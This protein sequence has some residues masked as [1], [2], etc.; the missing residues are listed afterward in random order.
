MNEDK[1]ALLLPRRILDYVPINTGSSDIPPLG[2]PVP[3]H[4]ATLRFVLV[5]RPHQMTGSIIDR[6][7]SLFADIV[8]GDIGM[9]P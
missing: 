3:I 8:N 4:G 7:Y 2:Q 5:K 1:L 6:D 9:F